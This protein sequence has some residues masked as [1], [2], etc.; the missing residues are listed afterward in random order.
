VENGQWGEG[1]SFLQIHD[2]LFNWM[3]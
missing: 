1:I 2:R 3:D